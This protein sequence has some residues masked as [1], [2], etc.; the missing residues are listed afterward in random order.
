MKICV[1]KYAGFCPG[2][3]R[4]D[5][6]VQKILTDTGNKCR[7]FTLGHLIHNRIY[8]EE[9]E[10]K[11][12][13]SIGFEDVDRIFFSSP[14]VPMTVVIRTHGIVKE[15]YEHLKKLE[16]ENSNFSLIDATCPFVKKIHNI[17]AENTNEDTCFLIYSDPGHPEAIGT[18]SYANGEKFAFSSL[19]ELKAYNF[20]N[21]LPIL[22]AQT[23]QNL[24]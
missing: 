3:R 13:Y 10:S 23:T 24:A 22:C 14:D 12:V 11:G 9:L 2:V 15:Q 20:G 4:A 17:A 18:L 19:E 8:N 21:K 5:E 7:I 6:T 16:S 1:S